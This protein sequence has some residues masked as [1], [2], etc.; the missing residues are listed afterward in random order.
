MTPT[1]KEL[2]GQTQ[3]PRPLPLH[4]A[5]QTMTWLS[6]LA[7]LQPLRNGS[8]SWR[9]EL[10][11]KAEALRRDLSAAAPDAF[12]AAVDAEA[13]RRL[14]AFADGVLTYRRHPRRPRPPEPP[15]VWSE[16]TTKLLDYGGSGAPLLVIP[17]LVNRAY[18]LDLDKERSL[19][20]YLA[21]RGFRPLLVDWG[22]PGPEERAFTLSDYIAGRLENALAA[23]AELERG[24]VGLI[25][26]CMGGLLATALAQRVPSKVSALALLATP[27]DFHAMEP[28]TTLMLKAMIPSIKDSVETIGVMP[29]D[30]LQAMFTG[31]N[32]FMTGEKF[33]RLASQAADAER[34]SRFVALEDW[35]NDG[36]PLAG[37][38][39]LEC[40][41]GW[42]VDN[43]PANGG[44]KVGDR[45][46]LPE[47]VEAPSLVV[48]PGKDHI[49]PPASA[50][51]LTQGLERADVLKPAAGHIGMVVG[52]TAKQALYIPLAQWLEETVG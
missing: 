34:T 11:Q 18:I 36:V 26:Y 38:V 23:A 28:V 9:P 46:V 35:L 51:A 8:L 15:C 27:W 40:L 25:G 45:P 17:S 29:V 10:A 24:P 7:A 16:G 41:S 42:Y 49:V 44:W 50:A 43:T 12:A 5:L 32:P 37:P 33:Q 31:L 22:E 1:P 13:R 30:M 3:G 2:Q 48:I 4:M 39:A 19:M 6:S 21:G 47:E 14:A 20:R 52:S